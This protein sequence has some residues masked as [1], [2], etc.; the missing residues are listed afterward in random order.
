MFP[1]V[2]AGL[3]RDTLIERILKRDRWLVLAALVGLASVAWGCMVRE[4]RAM[5]LTGACCCAGMA[6]SGPDV[7]PWNP[8]TLAPLFFM[9]SEMMI[10]MMIPSAAPMI[11][12]FS[13]VSRTR[14]EQ[15]RP[16]VPTTIFVLGYLVVW[17]SF[18][19]VAAAAQWLLHSTSLLSTSMVGTSP[20]LGGALLVAA[21]LFQWSPLKNACL[22]HCRSP[23]TFLMTEWREGRW[24]AFSMGLKHGIYCAGCCWLLMLL[25]FVVGVMN[26]YWIAIIA[27]LVLAEKLAPRGLAIGRICGVLC[28]AWGLWMIGAH[29]SGAS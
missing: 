20:F 28:S 18:S 4:A 21:G 9:W 25:L 3:E 10:A 22:E 16:Y 5:D 23:L 8:S 15:Q 7:R 26:L 11:L 17:T 1:A 6:M 14:R 19:A 24:Q 2:R 12:T 27:V 29:A 13:R